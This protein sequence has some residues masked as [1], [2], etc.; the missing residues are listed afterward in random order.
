MTSRAAPTITN[1]DVELTTTQAAR[2]L[3]VS[4]QHLADLCDRGLLPHRRI[5]THR[6]VRAEDLATHLD[7]LSSTISPLTRKDRVSLAI[8]YLVAKRLLTDEARVRARALRNLDTMRL[9]NKDHAATTYLA[10]WERLLEGPVERLLA[11][12]TSLDHRARDLRNVTPFAGVVTDA[13]RREL[14]RTI[15]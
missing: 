11:T 14:I 1:P 8:H 4:R 2:L 9:A 3:G 13:Q 12:L 5:G 15:R 10:E 6:R 7:A